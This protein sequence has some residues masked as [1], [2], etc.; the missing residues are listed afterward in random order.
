MKVLHLINT[1]SAG[2][3]ELHLLTLCRR[4]QQLGV[5][6]R[7]ACL[8]EL[9][10]GSRSLRHD[11]EREGIRV[12]ALGNTGR[13]DPRGFSAFYRLL[14]QERPDLLHSH[15]PRA[16]LVAF[17]GR[18]FGPRVLHVC[19]VHGIYSQT[20]AGRWVLPLVDS[21]WRRADAV[22]AISE[23]V[24][25][26]LVEQRRVPPARVTVVRYGVEPEAFQEC[27]QDLRQQWAQNGALVVGSLGRLEPG[28]GHDRLI[29]AWPAVLAR[30]PQATLLI[31]G[32]DPWGFGK[33]L[34]GLVK[35]LELADHVRLVGFQ[36]DV[37]SFLQAIDV[38][39]LASRSE[40]FGQAVI[41]AM[42]AGKPV[43]GS[44][45]APLTE[46]VREKETGLLVPTDDER[47]L[48]QALVWL[49]T[50]RGEATRMGARGRERVQQEFSAERMAA[51][52]LG[53]YRQLLCGR[54]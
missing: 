39:A 47:A 6:V 8:R 32:H 54:G 18:A 44:R 14:R 37:P 48:S 20:W 3:A 15:L 28:K 24:R 11:F 36:H 30:V 27:R 45:I 26:W 51:E 25:E 49:L 42:A 7:V 17:V 41:E 53:L 46:I 22:I 12:V 40:G 34:H 1:L 23:A 5:R 50:N 2:G 35:R 33:E 4:L 10:K 38:F 29:R 19:S 31:A 9:V 43:V 16:D 21:V 13:Y 52:T